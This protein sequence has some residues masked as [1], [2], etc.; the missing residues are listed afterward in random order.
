V[1]AV[2][3]W[4][5]Q[6][7]GVDTGLPAQFSY[8]ARDGRTGRVGG[9]APGCDSQ[10]V[11]E[12]RCDEDSPFD[13]SARVVSE[14]LMLWSGEWARGPRARVGLERDGD[15]LE[16]ASSPRARRRFARG[17]VQPP[18]EAEIRSRGM[19]ADRLMGR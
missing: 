19:G 13:P 5:A 17:G 3:E 7:H 18:S 8:S 2:W 14:H 10:A 12:G 9:T 4:A 16:G 6:C 1:Q 15:S 11:S